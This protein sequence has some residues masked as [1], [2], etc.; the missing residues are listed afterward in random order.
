M[1]RASTSS[2]E[3]LRAEKAFD[4]LEGEIV[5][6]FLV[7]SVPLYFCLAMIGARPFPLLGVG[8][9]FSPLGIFASGRANLGLISDSVVSVSS[10]VTTTSFPV[11][12]DREHSATIQSS[13]EVE[14]SV[15]YPS[16]GISVEG[17]GEVDVPLGAAMASPSTEI[18]VGRAVL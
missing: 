11:E 7:C 8:E 13:M 5:V 16:T 15:N 12:A 2:T 10:V 1:I 6:A 17:E 3:E 4:L 9:H 14:H 18:P